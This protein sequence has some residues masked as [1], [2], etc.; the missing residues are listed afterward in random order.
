M[1]YVRKY[2]K[3]SMRK[4]TRKTT[5]RFNTTKKK[6]GKVGFCKVIR[7][8][9]ADTT[10][11][12]HYTIQGNDVLFSNAVTLNFNMSNVA[13]ASELV[14][15]FD[16][17]RITKI[18]YRFVIQRNPDSVTT[19]ANKGIYPRLTWAHDFNDSVVATRNQIMQRANLKEYQFTDS[20]L[21]TP[22][23]TLKPSVLAVMYESATQSAYSPKWL[24]WLDTSDSATNYYGIKLAY[25]QCYAGMVVLMQCKYHIELKGIS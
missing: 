6:F 23:Y 18:D 14:G 25:D 5:R 21:Q 11:N 17:F 24:T 12:S 15:L 2:K 16:N 3:R 20:R 4:R 19:T 8:S 22:W 9:N 7:W 10:Y 1:P 13:A